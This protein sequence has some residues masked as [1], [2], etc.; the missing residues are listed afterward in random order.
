MQI[1]TVAQEMNN[2]HLHHDI[3]VVKMHSLT[4]LQLMNIII[5]CAIRHFLHV[6]FFNAYNMYLFGW[7]KIHRYLS[8]Y[9]IY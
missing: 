3:Y 6:N 1:R 9:K 5:N 8:L 7:S 2:E 4:L